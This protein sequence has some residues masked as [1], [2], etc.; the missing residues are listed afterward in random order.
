ML[1]LSFSLLLSLSLYFNVA[2][3]AC[4]VVTYHS[5]SRKGGKTRSQEPGAPD[6]EGTP[7]PSRVYRSVSLST[8]TRDSASRRRPRTSIS[9]AVSSLSCPLLYVPASALPQLLT[10]HRNNVGIVV[11]RL[12]PRQALTLTQV[13]SL[14]LAMNKFTVCPKFDKFPLLEELD[15]GANKLRMLS[16][17]V[18]FLPSVPVSVL[19][20]VHVPTPSA[21][22][23]SSI[24]RC[25]ALQSVRLR[26]LCRYCSYCSLN[27]LFFFLVS[28]FLCFLLSLTN[29]ASI[30]FIDPQLVANSNVLQNAPPELATLARL[31]RLDLRNNT[32]LSFP[33]E[34]LALTQLEEVLP[35]SITAPITLWPDL[36]EAYRSS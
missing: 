30:L 31:V 17:L 22:I 16:P 29:I 24:K 13:T 1:S 35:P 36:A 25:P 15:I 28:C 23:D 19:V 11:H 21:F 12:M 4:R 26:P 8:V 33:S 9:V 2:L 32:L 7:S 34:I 3:Y 20:L 14:R 6:S 18:P 10:F 27:S 5:C